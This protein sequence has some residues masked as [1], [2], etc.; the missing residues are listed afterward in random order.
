MEKHFDVYV[1]E[2]LCTEVTYDVQNE[3]VTIINHTDDILNRAFGTNEHPTIDDVMHFLEK[4]CFPK[5][6]ANI[7][8][9]LRLLDLDDYNVEEIVKKTEGR[10]EE[11]HKYV[12]FR[13]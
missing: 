2:T 7:K 9:L 13:S 5:E 12:I 4:R 3:T 1:N 11:D 8:T 6:R 10:M